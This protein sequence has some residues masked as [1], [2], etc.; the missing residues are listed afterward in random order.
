MTDDPTVVLTGAEFARLNAEITTLRATLAAREGECERLRAALA[1]IEKLAVQA[2][3]SSCTCLI[4]TP[5]ITFHDPGCRYV[6]LQYIIEQCEE[7][8]AA[9]TTP[10]AP[11]PWRPIETAPRDGTRVLLLI[12]PYGA[13]SGHWDEKWIG[14]FVLNREAPPTYW[15]PLPTPPQTEPRT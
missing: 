13:G 12:P 5:D 3:V 6:L 2:I 8:R 11:S 7:A 9:L 1:R 4:K 10:P 15:M 14:H